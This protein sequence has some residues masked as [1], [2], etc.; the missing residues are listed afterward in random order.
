[1]VVVF[2]HCRLS[3]INVPCEMWENDTLVAAQD[4]PEVGTSSIPKVVELTEQLTVVKK[5]SEVHEKKY[6]TKLYQLTDIP[7]QQILI[8]QKRADVLAGASGT[9]VLF[10]AS[11]KK[12]HDEIRDVLGKH[13]AQI[14]I[15]KARSKG[16]KA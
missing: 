8:Q 5:T 2:R 7:A 11:L 12:A 3:K 14:S 4:I 13:R 1:M 16:L 15:K 6:E 10:P 9:V